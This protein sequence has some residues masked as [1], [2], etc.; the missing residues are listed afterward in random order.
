[1]RLTIPLT[2]A[3]LLTSTAPALALTVNWIDWQSSSTAGG[4]FTASGQIVSGTETIDVTYTNSQG[5]SFI[6]TGTGTNYFTP[7]DPATSPYTSTGP[8]GNDNIPTAAEMIALNRQGSQ[9]LTFSQTVENLYLSFVSL[10]RNGY[11]FDQDLEILSQTGA[12]IDGAGTDAAGF[13]GTGLVT[14]VDNLD[15][16]FSINNPTAGEPHGTLLFASQFDTLTWNSDSNENWNG[17]TIGIQ[18]TATQVSPV[19]PVP[20][21][22]G[23]LLLLSGLVGVGAL[24]RRKKHTA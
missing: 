24:K 14:K 1:M 6:Q 4:G 7:T 9:T 18:G 15:G 3:A 16:T 12:D 20:L 17:F 21:P 22:A 2:L 11:T 23:G 19:S 8:L 10:N 13:W 5:V